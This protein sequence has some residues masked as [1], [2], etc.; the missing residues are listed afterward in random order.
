[1]GNDVGALEGLLQR[2]TIADVALAVGHLRLAV[3]VGVDRPTGDPD[4]ARDPFV[5][6]H[7]RHQAE[8]K[9]PGRTG[10]RNGEVGVA[11]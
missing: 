6:L 4:D 2:G 8:A 1:M 11:C 7:Q 10:N 3:L 5:G 9:C